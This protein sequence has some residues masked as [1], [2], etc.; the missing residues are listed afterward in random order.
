M[1]RLQ[2]FLENIFKEHEDR[3]ECSLKSY[4]NS[5]R[6]FQ[7]SLGSA[8]NLKDVFFSP[9]FEEAIRP[10]KIF[11]RDRLDVAKRVDFDEK[12]CAYP[13]S[14]ARLKQVKEIVIPSLIKAGNYWKDFYEDAFDYF[15]P[16]SIDG[17]SMNFATP[18]Q[19]I[20]SFEKIKLAVQQTFLKIKSLETS[21]AEDVSGEIF[22]SH[23]K[24]ISPSFK[25]HTKDGNWSHLLEPL[26]K[27]LGGKDAEPSS[28]T[29]FLSPGVVTWDLK[30]G[31]CGYSADVIN[32]D[33]KN[34]CVSISRLTRFS[35]EELDNYLV[36]LLARR[37]SNLYLRTAYRQDPSP[38]QGKSEFIE[39]LFEWTLDFSL[40]A[41][42]TE[43]NPN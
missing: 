4:F 6:Q 42:K 12:D 17:K 1:T 37:L 34:I 21:E 36:P 11:I 10:A 13:E 22:L 25:S 40:S 43:T 29:E 14:L 39:Q 3:K 5:L 27:V 18:E 15:E 38:D 41:S 2:N 8:Q 16:E 30:Q 23:L 20:A 31:A 26:R 24:E 19:V 28:I 35:P 9:D 7:Y 32:I 33:S